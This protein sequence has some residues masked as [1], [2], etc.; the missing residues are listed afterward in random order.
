MA[1]D[2]E[3][4]ERLLNLLEPQQ[5][6]SLPPGWVHGR[7]ADMAIGP[8][9]ADMKA[10]RK[11]NRIISVPTPESVKLARAAATIRWPVLD[12]RSPEEAERI[13]SQHALAV[14]AEQ[15]RLRQKN[16]P[17]VAASPEY[18]GQRP[19]RVVRI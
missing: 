18:S 11:G 6:A 8:P 13:W 9:V 12:L 1:Q 2:N 15:D 19:L 3:Q 17:K 14:H 7:L 5:D 10:V 16:A 4:S